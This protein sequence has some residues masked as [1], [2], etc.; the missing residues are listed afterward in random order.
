MGISGSDRLK[1][2][3]RVRIESRWRDAEGAARRSRSFR[4]GFVDEAPRDEDQ[5]NDE[6]VESNNGCEKEKAFHG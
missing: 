2:E 1:W 6:D 3:R 4:I 5:R